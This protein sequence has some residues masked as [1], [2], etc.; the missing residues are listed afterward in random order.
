GAPNLRMRM[1]V[2]E[3]AVV[4]SISLRL[5]LGLAAVEGWASQHCWRPRRLVA[6]P[7]PKLEDGCTQLEKR[8]F[9]P[10]SLWFAVCQCRWLQLKDSAILVKRSPSF[11]CWCTAKM[12]LLLQ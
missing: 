7:A 6:A 1:T 11:P 4:G 5:L 12:Q 2:H 9:H 10:W 8:E 3:L